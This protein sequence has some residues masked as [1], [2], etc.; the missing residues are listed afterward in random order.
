ML[1]RS[2][3][4]RPALVT[5]LARRCVSIA[6]KSAMRG[7]AM[8]GRARRIPVTS[9]IRCTNNRVFGDVTLTPVK[10]FSFSKRR[11]YDSA[12]IIPWCFSLDQSASPADQ[13]PQ[14]GYR[15]RNHPPGSAVDSAAHSGFRPDLNP[16]VNPA[17]FPGVDPVTGGFFGAGGALALAAAQ[18]SLVNV[19]QFGIRRGASLQLRSDAVGPDLTGKLRKLRSYAAFFGRTWYAGSVPVHFADPVIFASQFFTPLT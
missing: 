3:W 11:Q 18:V 15:L 2:W 14:R 5:L 10:R 9:R 8:S 13:L 16:V 4:C 6:R 19:P 1:V 12:E 17:N 7:P